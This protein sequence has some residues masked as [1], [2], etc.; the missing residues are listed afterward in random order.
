[1]TH[2]SQFQFCRRV[3]PDY[4]PSLI[5]KKTLLDTVDSIPG[6][7]ASW[8]LIEI[9]IQGTEHDEHGNLMT[10][11]VDM[12]V[13]NP[14][15][16]VQD[17]IGNPNYDGEIDYEPVEESVEEILQELSDVSSDQPLADSEMDAARRREMRTDYVLTDMNTADWWAR[18]QTLLSKRCPDATIAPVILASDKTQLSTFSGDKQGWPIYLTIGNIRKSVR[19]CPSRGAMVLLGYL[20]VAKLQCFRESERAVQGY[21]LFHYAMRELLAPLREAGEHGLMMTCADGRVR[22]VFPILAAYIADYP[23]QCLVCCTKGNRC[24]TCPVEPD[25]RGDL[26][27]TPYRDP[28]AALHALRDPQ[29]GGFSALGLRHVPEP[30]WADLPY[31]NIFNCIVPDL[32]H[33]LHKGVFMTHLVS[34]VSCGRESELDAR[35]ARV[36]PYTNLR[37]FKNGISTISQW[38]G[39]EYR[40][41]EKVLVGLLPGLHDDTRV[42][43][44]A[45]AILDF[46]YLAHYPSHTSAT[47]SQMRDA[48]ARFHANKQVFVDLG[49]RTHFNVHKLHWM[50]HYITSIIDFGSCDGLSTEISER[51]HIDYVKLAYRASNRKDYIQ[52]MLT[53]LARREKMKWLHDY[54]DWVRRDS[55]QPAHGASQAGLVSASEHENEEPEDRTMDKE[56]EMHSL[57]YEM[58]EEDKDAGGNQSDDDHQVSPFPGYSIASKPAAC[59]TGN[60]IIVA[61]HAHSFA[62][63][64]GCFIQQHAGVSASEYDLLRTPFAI[65]TRFTRTLPSLRGLAE[66]SFKDVVHAR[67]SLLRDQ[68]ARFSTVLFL[69]H[70]E[71]AET[72]GVQGYRVAQVRVLFTLP[73]PLQRLLTGPLRAQP[74]LAYV[75]LFT[76]FTD[77]EPHSGLYK[78]TRCYSNHTRKAIIIPV[79]RIFRSCH[80]IPAFGPRAN[81]SWTSHTVLEDCDVF[82]LNA[83]SDHHMYLFV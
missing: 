47:L 75:E 63:A 5:D 18:I 67:P 48:L 83:F 58:I 12:W 33:Q 32:L 26:L 78:V 51:L 74:H 68:Q 66:E 64:L 55:R 44:A 54:V 22:R 37:V 30:F 53:W 41:M 50:Q 29:S 52:Q 65:Y 17:L 69:E 45:R 81:R 4:F 20:P 49:I 13:R 46:I 7:S 36:P 10:E 21:R 60:E 34:W 39:N 27:E 70:P 79:A 15:A 38:T 57:C 25:A 23:E 14:V 80:L 1:M 9:T 24:P 2:H 77:P 40:Q 35:F 76:Q 72:I 3:A 61:Y 28:A 11:T 82:Y 43:A 62:A 42:V 31:A 16:V 19:R 56:S 6:P 73:P 8:K 59:L 71:V